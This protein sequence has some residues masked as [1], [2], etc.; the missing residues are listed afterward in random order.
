MS[1]PRKP[2][3]WY[4]QSGVVPLRGGAGGVEV[5]LVTSRSGK[6]WLIP[7]GIVEPGLSATESA[8]REAWEEAGV[9]GELAGPPLGTYR[10][11]KW[12]GHC[13]VTV[14]AMVVAEEALRWP[15]Q[16]V[17]ERRWFGAVEAARAVQRPALAGLIQEAVREFRGEGGP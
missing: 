10:Y 7:K 17:R 9:R 14:H 11:R 12:G 5:L 8:L 2:E 3:H 13:T 4:V 1:A 6:R 16:E 15:E